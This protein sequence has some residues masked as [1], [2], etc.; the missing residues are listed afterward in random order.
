MTKYLVTKYSRLND[1][2][3]IDLDRFVIGAST[4]EPAGRGTAIEESIKKSHKLVSKDGIYTKGLMSW[5]INSDAYDGKI[6]TIPQGE[7]KDSLIIKWEKW[8]FSKWYKDIYLQE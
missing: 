3:L 8:T 4:N 1:F 2:W 5:T 6:A 7:G